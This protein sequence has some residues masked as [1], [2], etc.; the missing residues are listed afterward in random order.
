LAKDYL[1][2]FLRTLDTSEKEMEEV[3]AML[4]RAKKKGLF[5][6]VFA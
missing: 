6:K 4:K 1:N 3:Q 2:A 5:S